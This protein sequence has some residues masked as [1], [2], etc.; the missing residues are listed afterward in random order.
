MQDLRSRVTCTKCHQACRVYEIKKDLCT[1]CRDGAKSDI[2]YLKNRFR[3]QL[4]IYED[5]GKV[6]RK[7]K[8]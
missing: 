3:D 2:L 5:T 4:S 6:V 8:R 1:V 7:Y